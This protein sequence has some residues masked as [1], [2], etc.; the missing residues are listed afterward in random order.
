MAASV[1]KGWRLG[2]G[3]C[4]G[5]DEAQSAGG[6]SSLL[7]LLLGARIGGR[8]AGWQVVVG[9]VGS[10][11]RQEQRN[12]NTKSTARETKQNSILPTSSR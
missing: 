1:E 9:R 5:A 3:C 7:V 8:V 2:L 10:G 12:T 11:S 6:R 4:R